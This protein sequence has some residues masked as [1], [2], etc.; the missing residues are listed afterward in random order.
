[1]E[2]QFRI[3]QLAQQFFFILCEEGCAGE[4]RAEKAKLRFPSDIDELKQK[5]QDADVRIDRPSWFAAL[6]Q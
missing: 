6:L 1:M 3:A 5:L 2:L 4:E